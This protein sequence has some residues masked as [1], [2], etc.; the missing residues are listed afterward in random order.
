MLISKRLN[1]VVSVLWM[2]NRRVA[3]FYEGDQQFWPN[4]AIDRPWSRCHMGQSEALKMIAF[5]EEQ[6]NKNISAHR[7]YVNDIECSPTVWDIVRGFLIPAVYP[8]SLRENNKKYVYPALV[9]AMERKWS[10]FSP[11]QFNVIMVDFVQEG[12]LNWI[13]AENV[14]N[15]KRTGRR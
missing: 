5:T 9:S 2:S 13:I 10:N 4:S 14:K 3:V 1:E 6:I 12:V 15:G 11:F 7:L 8:S